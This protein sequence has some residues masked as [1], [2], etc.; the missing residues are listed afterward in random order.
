MPFGSYLR[1]IAVAVGLSAFAAILAAQEHRPQKPNLR[2]GPTIG[3]FRGIVGRSSVFPPAPSGVLVGSYQ[4]DYPNRFLRDA[5]TL[6]G[7]VEFGTEAL[8]LQFHLEHRSVKE[9]FI[10]VD[11][12]APPIDGTFRNYR[13]SEI[14]KP[15]VFAAAGRIRLRLVTTGPLSLAAI[16]GASRLLERRKTAVLA[17]LDVRHQTR[18][19]TWFIEAKVQRYGTFFQGLDQLYRNGV[20]VS[21]PVTDYH[22]SL[23]SGAVRFGLLPGRHH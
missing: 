16:G 22:R 17:G 23:V 4:P 13:T 14:S 9:A 18:I 1:S 7:L 5:V 15:A 21:D 2:A 6:G 12:V 20:V 11:P 8:A 10:V 3:F 19:G